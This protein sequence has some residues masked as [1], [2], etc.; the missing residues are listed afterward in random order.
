MAVCQVSDVEA[1]LRRELRDDD[2]NDARGLITAY[3]AEL[4]G[5]LGRSVEQRAFTESAPWPHRTDRFYV[6]WGPIAS[7]TEVVVAGS[8][9]NASDYE[10]HR[11][12][13]EVSTW[14]GTPGVI[15]VSYVGGWDAQRAAP[16][17]AAV[18]AR[19]ARMMARHD[20]DDEGVEQSSVEGHQVRWQA[21]AFTDAE[22]KSCERLRH[23]DQAG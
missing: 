17:K 8:P 5:L 12:S 23:P 19:V 20:E 14:L 1:R 9:V 3:Q 18:A 11:D 16:A 22:L 21:D 10:V 13:V 4:E 6:H 7:V 15:Q 2:E